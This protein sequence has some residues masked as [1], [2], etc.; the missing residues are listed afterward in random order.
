MSIEIN[1]IMSAIERAIIK[2][3]DSSFVI[4][5]GD[6]INAKELVKRAYDNI[7]KDKLV[8]KITNRL[9]DVIAE[10]VVNKITT[11]M[12]NDIKGLMERAEIREDF[13]YVLRK[14]VEYILDKLK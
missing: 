8:I 2:S 9:E 10:K 4:D 12:G 11:E 3:L 7:D 14:N 13:K 6:R 5:L 1:N